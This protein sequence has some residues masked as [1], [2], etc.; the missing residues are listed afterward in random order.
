MKRSK[1][2]RSAAATAACWAL[3]LG[4]S[5]AA[6]PTVAGAPAAPP[7]VDAAA[8]PIPLH[9]LDH[10]G[11]IPPGWYY[12]PM[13]AAPDSPYASSGPF[14]LRAIVRI[15]AG[16]FT[17]DGYRISAADPTGD[18]EAA[19]F[20]VRR[21]ISLVDTEPCGG[22]Q[23]VD[24]GPSVQNLADALAP[25]AVSPPRPVRVNGWEGVSLEFQT[26]AVLTACPHGLYRLMSD[27]A[28]GTAGT[29]R[30]WLLDVEGY[31]VVVTL[32]IPQPS[33]PGSDSLAQ[34]LVFVHQR[35]PH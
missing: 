16:H 35:A 12:L 13:T 21:G 34:S 1:V 30:L 26:P 31:R 18:R 2:T 20:W 33:A 22:G 11:P 23:L 6:A 3:A 4:G 27:R 5:A 17:A 19:T 24:P 8:E 28:E 10:R 32:R 14:P 25:H 7:V 9:T 29:S 15:P